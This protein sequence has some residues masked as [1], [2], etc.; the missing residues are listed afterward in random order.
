MANVKTYSFGVSY[1][2]GANTVKSTANI[3]KN[4]RVAPTRSIKAAAARQAARDAKHAANHA[5]TTTGTISVVGAGSNLVNGLYVQNGTLN[6]HPVYR[7]VANVAYALAFDSVKWNLKFGA[8]VYYI[9]GATITD[10]FAVAGVHVGLDPAPGV[11]F[12]TYGSGFYVKAVE[13][14]TPMLPSQMRLASVRN[15][16]YAYCA[17]NP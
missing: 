1:K 9:G 7:Q 17:S 6:G 5:S 15:G 3:I 2:V 13:V 16:K 4:I 10:S 8:I 11:G 14:T 12:L